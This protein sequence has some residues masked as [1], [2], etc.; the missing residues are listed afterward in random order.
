MITI[1]GG[2]CYTHTNLELN[3]KFVRCEQ[4]KLIFLYRERI[5]KKRYFEITVFEKAKWKIKEFTH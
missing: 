2:I 3:L 1:S 4:N 5:K